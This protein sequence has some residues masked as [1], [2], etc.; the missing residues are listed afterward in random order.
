MTESFDDELM[1][2]LDLLDNN[3]YLKVFDDLEITL[4]IKYNIEIYKLIKCKYYMYID[5]ITE[6]LFF[7]KISFNGAETNY[8][9]HEFKKLLRLKG[10]W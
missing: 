4:G 7:Y 1:Y 8:T 9:S 5:Y 6:N 3:D 2:C 10:F